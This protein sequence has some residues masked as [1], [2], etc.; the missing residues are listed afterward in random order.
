MDTSIPS[1][2][3][4]LTL[5]TRVRKLNFSKHDTGNNT[6]LYCSLT[7][8]I[9]HVIVL[10]IS[11]TASFSTFLFFIKLIGKLMNIT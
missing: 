11:V 8:Y 9:I 7:Y 6:L 3:A 5:P 4:S 10:S 2:Q 1:H